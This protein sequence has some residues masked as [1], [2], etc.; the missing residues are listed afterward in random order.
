MACNLTVASLFGYS[1]TELISR[2]VNM[3]QP[4]LYSKNHDDILKHYLE[5]SEK[6]QLNT[7]DK[8]L[9]IYGKNKS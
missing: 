3:L 1:K 2:N 7:K 5:N 9:N 4:Y 8:N 6:Q